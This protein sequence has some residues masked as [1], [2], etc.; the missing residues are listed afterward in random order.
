MVEKPAL[1]RLFCTEEPPLGRFFFCAGFWKDL[2]THS[3]RKCAAH[4]SQVV[5]ASFHTLPEVFLSIEVVVPKKLR[6]VAFV[7]NLRTVCLILRNGVFCCHTVGYELI[8]DQYR[9]CLI[10]IL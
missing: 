7:I 1:R 5:S 2:R 9:V 4:L 8:I 10:K 6:T 3:S